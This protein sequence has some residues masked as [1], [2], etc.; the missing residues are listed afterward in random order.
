MSWADMSSIDQSR[1]ASLLLDAVEKGAFLLANNLYEG[2]FSDRAPNVGRWSF[3]FLAILFCTLCKSPAHPDYFVHICSCVC[4][5]L[6]VYVLNTEADIQD[7]T[8]PHSYDSDSILEISATALQQ[9]SNNGLWHAMKV[10]FYTC[11]S[12]YSA[13]HT[14]SGPLV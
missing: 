3:C 7:L 13:Q 4:T 12:Q 1:S 10:T 2:R 6:E 9:Y 11:K 14:A 8:F 5:D